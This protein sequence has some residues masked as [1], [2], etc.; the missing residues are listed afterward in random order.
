YAHDSSGITI[1]HNLLV[2]NADCGVMLR[3][4]SERVFHGTL[5]HTS[6]TRVLNNL[7]WNNSR[8][9]ISLPWPGPR[10]DDNLSDY[11]VLCGTRDVW[12]GFEPWPGLFGV[13]LYKSTDVKADALYGILKETLAKAGVPDTELPQE[14]AWRRYPTLTLAQWRLLMKQDLHSAEDPQLITVAVRSDVPMLTIR[15]KGAALAMS[16]PAVEGVDRD[17]LGRPLQPGSIRPG[18]FQDLG[19]EDREVLLWPLPGGP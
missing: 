7:I 13:N 2:G 9:A 14:K 11:N 8:P 15:G 16:C 1:A 17:Y 10:A 5:V 4:I 19:A 6:H 12:L 18:P 3:T